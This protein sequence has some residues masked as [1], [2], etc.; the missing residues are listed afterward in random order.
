MPE[1]TRKKIVDLLKSKS[2][3]KQDIFHNT[4]KWFDLFKV[5]LEDCLN[6]IKSEIG[7]EKRIRLKYIDKGKSEAQ[8]YIGSDVLIFHMH[9]NVF[10]FNKTNYVNQTSY[11]QN[12]PDNA[13]CGIINIYNFLAD[14]YEYGRYN[15]YGYLIARIFINREDHFMVEGKGQLGFMYRDFIN[16]KI[17]KETILEIIMKVAI[18]AIEFDLLTPPYDK[19]SIVSVQEMQAL[20][21][22]SQ[23]KTGKRLGFKFQ[24]DNNIEG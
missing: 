5:E 17:D 2:C 12:E 16:Q 18:D 11:V 6:L 9:S 7:E 24:S 3:L 1:E 13:Y 21:S 14:S 15:D 8:L 19:I 23:L 20:S 4:E 22:D 10:R